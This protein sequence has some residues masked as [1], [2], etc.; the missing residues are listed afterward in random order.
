MKWK[1][2]K[3]L[4]GNITLQMLTPNVGKVKHSECIHPHLTI[5]M[6]LGSQR[7]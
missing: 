3:M 6:T 2:A 1:D 4:N 5:P 7:A